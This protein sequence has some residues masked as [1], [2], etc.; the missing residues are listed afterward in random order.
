MMMM[1]TKQINPPT[2]EIRGET[3][4]EHF[5]GKER[6]EVMLWTTPDMRVFLLLSSTHFSLNICHHETEHKY[7]QVLHYAPF[8]MNEME[9]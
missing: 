2:D 1:I 5:T 8:I 6:Q 4:K 7:Y 3:E 9:S